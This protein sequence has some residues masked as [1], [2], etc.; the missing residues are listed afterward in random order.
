MHIF[1]K[2]TSNPHKNLTQAKFECGLR[3]SSLEGIS[4]FNLIPYK[5]K[6]TKLVAYLPPFTEHA[7]KSFETMPFRQNLREEVIK[8][9]GNRPQTVCK[10]SALYKS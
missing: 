3:R 1:T 9:V 2:P 7:K 4:K 8:P 10:I 6:D 5:C